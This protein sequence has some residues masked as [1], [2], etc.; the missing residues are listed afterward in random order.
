MWA[1]HCEGRDLGPWAVE[2]AGEAGALQVAGLA[3]GLVCVTAE[4]RT[5]VRG[6]VGDAGWGRLGTQPLACVCLRLC[7]LLLMQPP[8]SLPSIPLGTLHCSFKPLDMDSHSTLLA[9]LLLP[10]LLS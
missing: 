4:L 7:G 6:R 10:S 2:A 5:R 1:H 9:T 3:P 8:S